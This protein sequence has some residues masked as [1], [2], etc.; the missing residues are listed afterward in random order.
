MKIEKKIW[1]QSFE[2]IQGGDKTFEL[3]LGDFECKPGDTLVLKEW[4]PEAKA[5]TGREVEKEVTYVVRTTD[6]KFWSAEDVAKYGYQV[7]AFK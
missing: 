7:I 2:E 3:R 5:Y 4:N 1:P 6:A